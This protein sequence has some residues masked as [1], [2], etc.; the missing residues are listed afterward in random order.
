MCC[1]T[2]WPVC[3]EPPTRTTASVASITLVEWTPAGWH[4]QN[5][6]TQAAMAVAAEAEEEDAVVAAMEVPVVVIGDAVFSEGTPLNLV[7]TGKLRSRGIVF[8]GY[9]D[10][11]VHAE[12]GRVVAKIIWLNDI[13]T[14]SLDSLPANGN[15]N[16]VLVAIEEVALASVDY[17]A[18]HR[19]LMHANANKPVIETCNLNVIK[20]DAKEAHAY[21]CHWCHL[22]KSTRVISHDKL[23]HVAQ[24]FQKSSAL[25]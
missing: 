25:I 22:G 4:T 2:L 20:M 18:M 5:C 11:L 16:A 15:D 6:A 17:A 7:S 3:R 13:A 24:P 12:S 23:P 19:R 21:K 10:L 1:P 8:D 14:F 9:R